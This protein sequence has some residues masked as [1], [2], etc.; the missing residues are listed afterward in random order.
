MCRSH[1]VDEYAECSSVAEGGAR[2]AIAP[3]RPV[4]QNAELGKDHV[5]SSSET[6]F[7]VLEWNKKWFK[8]SFET[9]IQGGGG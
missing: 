4:N 8:A 5:F 9:H 6:F 2:E 1:E 7:F 3:H